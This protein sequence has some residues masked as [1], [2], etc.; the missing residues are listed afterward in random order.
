MLVN[1]I[2]A[3]INTLC[4]VIITLVVWFL[5]IEYKRLQRTEETIRQYIKDNTSKTNNTITK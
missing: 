3:A 2:I 1:G 4:V 5:Y